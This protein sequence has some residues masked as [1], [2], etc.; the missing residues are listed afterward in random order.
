[1]VTETLSSLSLLLRES[2]GGAVDHRFVLTFASF[3]LS[4]G[5]QLSFALTI[6]VMLQD[7]LLQVP[8]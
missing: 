2:T 1:M 6:V 5:I 4:H 7:S 3:Q 8:A